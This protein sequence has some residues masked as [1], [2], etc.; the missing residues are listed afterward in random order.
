MAGVV[1]RVGALLTLHDDTDNL[2][3]A[4]VIDSPKV[5]FPKGVVAGG[6]TVL[7]GFAGQSIPQA[8]MTLPPPE[9]A[10]VTVGIKPAHFKRGGEAT[11][12]LLVEGVAYLGDESCAMQGRAQLGF[13]QENQ[14]F[15][16]G[17][18]PTIN[19]SLNGS[20]LTH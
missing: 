9:G 20:T 3:V 11:L 10:T 18:G 14:R 8:R 12:K 16:G 13:V 15:G 19:K 5:S 6:G 17:F 1:E 7:S 4:G 2:F